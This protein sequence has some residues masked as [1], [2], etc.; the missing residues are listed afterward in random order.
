MSDSLTIRLACKEDFERCTELIEEFCSE[1]LEAF[2]FSFDKASVLS[3]A[4][5]HIDTTW[6]L[7]QDGILTGFLCGMIVDN[8]IDGRQVFQEIAWFVSQR[9][10]RY[11]L[12][13]LHRVESELKLMG[14]NKFIMVHM[15]DEKAAKIGA[16]YKRCGFRPLETQ[17]IKELV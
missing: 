1:T 6:V 4:T 13:L 2:G 8:L 3:M 10:R 16:L 15:A 17:Y 11:G 5:T 14:I 7:V 12:R 9:H